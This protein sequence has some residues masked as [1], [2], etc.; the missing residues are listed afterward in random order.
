MT[1]LKN[2]LSSLT[3]NPIGWAIIAPWAKVGNFIYAQR[4]HRI[5]LQ[6]EFVQN[7]KLKHLAAPMFPEKKV[8]YGPFAGLKYPTFEA[9]GSALFPKLLGTYEAELHSVIEEICQ[10]KYSYI[11]NIG[12]GEGY[13]AIGLALRISE[14]KI[15]AF[16]L[17]KEAQQLTQEMAKLN[18]CNNRIDVREACTQDFIKQFNFS[19]RGL[20]VCDCEGAEKELFET[21]LTNLKNCD[22]LIEVH[23]F[24]DITISSQLFKF[25][26][27]T[28]TI[29]SILSTDDL[30]KPRIYNRPELSTLSLQERYEILREGRPTIM[31]WLYIT[32]KAIV[33]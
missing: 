17:N 25:F 16:D 26:N 15:I 20:I 13:Y 27:S 6:K 8:L 33:S 10:K 28:H 1:W 11:I 23:D 31:E 30:H 18:Q 32:P 5:K 4:Q 29:Q 24:I 21:A 3:T 19:G 22:L 7:E 12:C 2:I 9:K 14:S